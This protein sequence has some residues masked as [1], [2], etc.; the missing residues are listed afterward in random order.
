MD[1]NRLRIRIKPK[2]FKIFRIRRNETDPSESRS[3][4]PQQ[5]HRTDGLCVS[6]APNNKELIYLRKIC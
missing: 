4:T 1:Q 6:V 2:K 3:K 5:S